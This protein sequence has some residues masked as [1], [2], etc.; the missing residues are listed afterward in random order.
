MATTI[1]SEK[2]SAVV[3]GSHQGLSHGEIVQDCLEKAHS[4]LQVFSHGFE[5][6]SLPAAS[7]HQFLATLDDLVLQALGHYIVFQVE[8]G[9]DDDT[10]IDLERLSKIK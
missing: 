8:C 4:L 10:D 7:Q 1:L 3:L 9:C 6:S 5:I 2:N